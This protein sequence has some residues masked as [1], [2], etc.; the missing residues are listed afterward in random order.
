MELEPAINA[1]SEKK[2]HKGKLNKT[3]RERERCREAESFLPFIHQFRV[4]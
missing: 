2:K 1:E 4:R 3:E